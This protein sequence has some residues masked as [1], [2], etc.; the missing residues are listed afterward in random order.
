[1]GTILASAIVADAAELL[2]DRA[3]VRWTKPQLL[4]WLNAGMREVVIGSPNAYVTNV[5]VKLVAGTKQTLPNGGI[6]LMDVI[7]NMGTTGAVPGRVPR[8][9]ERKLIDTQNPNWHADSANATVQH[10]VYDDRDQ[11]HFYVWPRQPDAN[12]GYVEILFSAS[13][14]AL[15]A[16]T[17]VLPLDDVYSNAL[18]NYLM[19]RAYSRDPVNSAKAKDYYQQF[20]FLITGK[21][22]VDGKNKPSEATE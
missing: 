5:A 8:Y 20:V 2:Q 4:N 7:R 19:Y 22:Q 14:P 21:D 15:I 1:M 17:Q 13:P 10:Y 6:L 16:D 18:V 3:N 11:D 12:Q 9:I